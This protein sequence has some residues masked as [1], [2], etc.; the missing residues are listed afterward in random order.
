MYLYYKL[1]NEYIKFECNNFIDENNY[2]NI[3]LTKSIKKFI[4][5]K[6]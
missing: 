2:N 4:N 3:K 6:I 1:N 5:E